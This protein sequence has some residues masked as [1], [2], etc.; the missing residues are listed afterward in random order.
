MAVQMR[1]SVTDS[2]TS[3]SEHCGLNRAE[4]PLVGGQSPDAADLPPFVL[5]GTTSRIAAVPPRHAELPRRREHAASATRQS[6]SGPTVR[7]DSRRQVRWSSN[8]T[9]LDGFAT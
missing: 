7:S 2:F 8:G 3:P 4:Q 1:S 9:F 5:L 6:S